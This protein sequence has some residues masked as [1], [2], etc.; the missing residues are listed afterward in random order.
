[1][2]KKFVSLIK[3][4]L[5]FALGS[6]GSKIILFFLVPLYTNYLTSE[7]YGIADLVFTFSQLLT[8]ILSLVVYNGVLRYGLSKDEKKEDA[9]LIGYIVLIIGALV[10]V[11]IAP[12][13][14]LYGSISKWKWYLIAYIIIYNFNSLNMVYLKIKDKNK[15]YAIISIIQTASLA[16]LNI[17]LLVCFNLNIEGYLLANII[18]VLLSMIISLIVGGVIVDIRK[19]VFRKDLFVKILRYSLPL[20]LND[21]SWWIIHSSDKIMI[22][23][24]L[25]SSTLGLYTIATKIPA[26]INVF[27]S[28]FSQAWGISSI[29]EIESTKETGFYSGVFKVYSFISFLAPI[30]IL[31]VI[32]IFMKVYV[33]EEYYIAWQYTPLLL[34]AASFSAISTY[35]GSLY[36]ALKRNVN[37]MVTTI[38]AAIV[39][40]VA[41]Y[42]FIK[43]YGI[44]GA[45]IGTILAY[46]VISTIR[47][48]DI[49][50]YMHI[51]LDVIR[52]LLNAI[53][54]VALSILVSMDFCVYLSC[55]IGLVSFLTINGSVIVEIFKTF[56]IRSENEDIS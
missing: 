53:I 5:V 38:I 39:N 19:A 10:S 12:L 28:I 2:N 4:T 42:V 35:F 56:F 47:M 15:S 43:L 20:I 18:A 3:D 11:S 30:L 49:Y 17:V 32:K 29:K 9:L 16:G 54:V 34:A 26:L 45:L 48:I 13:L 7:E 44:W 31:F 50:R 14:N 23:A 36:G 24:M 25:D 37:S 41:N 52:Y 55:A 33:A 51:K 8:P 46:I 22:D 6:I 1:M 21:I 40:I 27:I